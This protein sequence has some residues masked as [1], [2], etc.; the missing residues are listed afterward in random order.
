MIEQTE[1]HTLDMLKDSSG[2]EEIDGHE[3]EDAKEN[4]EGGKLH[5]TFEVLS[6]IGDVF[7]RRF[8]T[9]PAH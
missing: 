7:L 4:E 2:I 8:G 9:L 3:S 6:H 5:G 1:K